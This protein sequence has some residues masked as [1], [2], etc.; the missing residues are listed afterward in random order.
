MAQPEMNTMMSTPAMV[1]ALVTKPFRLVGGALIGAAAYW[2]QNSQR[3]KALQE[4]AE[5]TD[6]EL[7]DL[8]LSRH[9]AVQR[10][11]GYMI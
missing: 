3:A 11:V 8:G 1:W 6:E 9:Q 4:V 2:E 5:M 7:A 10:A